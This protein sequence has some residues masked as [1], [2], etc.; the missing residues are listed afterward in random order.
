MKKLKLL[1]LAMFAF[2]VFLL[3]S[4]A[5]TPQ[6]VPAGEFGQGQI[7]RLDRAWSDYSPLQG[8]Y[9]AK[10]KVKFLTI[11]G[12]LLN[13]LYISEGLSEKDPLFR[14]TN[15]EDKYNPAPRPSKEMSLLEQ[16]EFVS[17]S[18]NELEYIKVSTNSPKSVTIA[19]ERGVRF[20]LEMQTSDGLIMRGLA[21]AFRK[22]SLNYYII[23]IAPNIHYYE[24][25][26]ASVNAA[27]DSATIK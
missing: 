19:G 25:N 3:T 27:M 12:A 10:T 17:K 18:L 21:Q 4:C 2:P 13:R 16:M 15:F 11:D 22:N 7:V 26:L 1:S 5:V 14:K 9:F 24:A 6:L 20:G 8:V 23:Y